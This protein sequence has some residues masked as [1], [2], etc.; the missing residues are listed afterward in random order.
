MSRYALLN[1]NSIVVNVIVA[2]N[3][4]DALAVGHAVEISEE[5]IHT[6]TIGAYYNQEDNT[7]GEAV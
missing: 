7:F 5:N 3:L 1:G 2:D 4:S 6:A